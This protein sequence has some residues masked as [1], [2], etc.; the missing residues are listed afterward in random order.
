MPAITLSLEKKYIDYLK[1][2]SELQKRD[3]SSLVE[4]ALDEQ[5]IE[6]KE[7]SQ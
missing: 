3:M 7:V 4:L 1:S 5:M 6:D 2:E